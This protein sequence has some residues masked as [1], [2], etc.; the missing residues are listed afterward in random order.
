[1]KINIFLLL[2]GALLLTACGAQDGEIETKDAWIRPAMQAENSAMYMLLQNHTS[3]DDELVGASSDVADAVELHKSM[4]DSNGTMQM[5]HQDSVPLSAGSE[6]EFAPGGLH[7]MFV[8]L[9]KDL[10]LGDTV[11]VILQFKNHADLSLS[12]PVQNA[13]GGQMPMGESTH[14]P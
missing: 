12:V 6:V 3:Q 14:T 11:E 10:K 5:M 13:Q 2:L 8:G 4:M 1:M 9:K 7:V